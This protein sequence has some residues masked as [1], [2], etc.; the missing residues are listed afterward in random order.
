MSKSRVVAAAA[1][2]A[3]LL[4]IA[5]GSSSGE[6]ATT[7]TASGAPTPSDDQNAEQIASAEAF[8]DAFYSFDPDALAATLSSAPG[9]VARMLSYQGWAE[10]GNYKVLERHGCQVV[11]VDYVECPVTVEDDLLLNLG[12]DF[13]VTD[14]FNL[15]FEGPSIIFV[16]T[17]SDDPALVSEAFDWVFKNHPEFADGPCVGY[18]VNELETPQECAVAVTTAFK[19]FAASDEFPGN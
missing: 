18:E 9:S 15:S 7:T 14:Q 10:G 12:S 19:E 4:L 16:T 5:C 13:K 2:F 11:S 6:S 3:C 8:V 1:A 17:K